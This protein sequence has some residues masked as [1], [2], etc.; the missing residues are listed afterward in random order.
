[1]PLVLDVLRHGE[2]LPPGI[3]GDAVRP[4]SPAG[5]RALRRLAGELS[6]RAWRPERV[7]SSPL[8]R[9]L[10]TSYIVVDS[11]P[12]RVETLEALRPDG[13]P[14]EV[15]RALEEAEALDGHVLLIGHQPLLGLLVAWLTGAQEPGFHPATLLRIECD[16]GLR[17]G[18]GRLTLALHPA[19]SSLR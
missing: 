19:S 13:E 2:A 6:T 17:R 1:V 15:L 3:D 11:I 5:Q 4:L 18:S 12:C 10:E 14:M 7:F 8:R 16:G 9:A